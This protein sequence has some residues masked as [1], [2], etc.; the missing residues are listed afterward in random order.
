MTSSRKPRAS[1][2]P[3]AIPSM[4]RLCKLAYQHEPGLLLVAFLLTLFAALPD[5]LIAVWLK[6]LGDGV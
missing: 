3:P 4:W 1:D 5:S 2:L 6:L